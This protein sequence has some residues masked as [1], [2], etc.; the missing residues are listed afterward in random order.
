MISYLISWEWASLLTSLYWGMILS[1]EYDCIRIFRRVVKHYKIWVMSL[2]DIL[3]WINAGITVFCITY[4]LN[5]GIIR[6]FS[7][8][9]LLAGAIIYRYSFGRI[10]VKYISKLILFVLKPLKKLAGFIKMKFKGL[11]RLMAKKAQK[12]KKTAELKKSTKKKEAAKP[13]RNRKPED[14]KKLLKAGTK[15][16]DKR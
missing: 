1:A 11:L 9:G 16:R 3:F 7:I 15:G 2:E 4:E 6:G 8:A 12:H 13:D 10:F 14:S 5:D